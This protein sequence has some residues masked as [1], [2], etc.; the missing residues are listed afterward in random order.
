M[1]KDEAMVSPQLVASYRSNSEPCELHLLCGRGSRR[2]QKRTTMSKSDFQPMCEDR[3]FS[4][5]KGKI[6]NGDTAFLYQWVLKVL[7]A[8]VSLTLSPWRAG[9]E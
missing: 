6:I 1:A 9:R 8:G 3:N 5:Q 7:K 2:G 4:V